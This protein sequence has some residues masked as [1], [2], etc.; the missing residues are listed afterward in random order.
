MEI[1]DRDRHAIRNIISS[2]LTAFQTD[3]AVEAFSYATSEIQEQ[4]KTPELFLMMV[5]SA[6][7]P[8]YRP[9][10][11]LFEDIITVQGFPTQKVL[12]L[13]AENPVRAL[14][15]MQQQQGIW[16]IAGCF[17]QPIEENI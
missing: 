11:V 14:Y 7:E 10:S 13:G 6:Y 5:K 15:L 16:R 9:R 17:L 12:L 8:V 4:F 2:Q 3:N 1:S